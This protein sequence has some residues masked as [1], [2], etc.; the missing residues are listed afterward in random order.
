MRK[1]VFL[2]WIIVCSV[3]AFGQQTSEGSLYATG[4]Q[5]TALGACPLKST[6]MKADISGFISR[7]TVRQEFENSF[8]EPIEAVYVFPLS[9]NGA[10]DTMT[11]TIGT[12]IIRGRIMR[13]EEAKSSY[14]TAKAAGRTAALLDQERTNIFTQSVANIM[15]G[16][17]VIVEISYVETLKYEDGAYEFVFPMTVAPRYIPNG[18]KDAEKITP[19]ITTRNGSD[20]TLEVNLNAGVPVEEI[21][22][23][24][25]AID[26]INFSPNSAKITLKDEKTIP[27][28]DFILRYDV[29]GKRIE[30]AVLTHR[31]ARGGFFT[32]ILQPPDKIATEDRTPK[33]IVFVLDTSGSM[34]GFP[35]EKAKEAMKLSLEG[36]YPEDTFNIITFAGDTSI[37]F[38]RPVPATRANLDA[39]QEFLSTRRGYGGTE[40]M[41]AIKAALDPSDSQEHLRIV[42]FMTDAEVGNDDQIIAEIQRHPNARVFS[43]GI[44]SSVNR[45]LLD[46]MAAEGKGEVEYVGLQ[47]DGSAAAKRF[48]ERVRTPLLTD[49]SIDW[50]GMPVADV[51]PAKLTDL[52]SAKPV[53]LHGRYTKAAAGAIK[54]KGRLAGQPY[55]RSINV[56][57]AETEN[58]NDALSTLWARTRIDELSMTRLKAADE[59]SGKDIDDVITNIG[60]DFGLMTKFTSFLAVEDKV[61]NPNGNPTQI[62]VPS[63]LPEGMQN[64]NTT[65]PNNDEIARL[66]KTGYYNPGSMTGMMATVEVSSTAKTR[67]KKSPNDKT[68]VGSGTGSGRGSGSGSGIG[69]GSGSGT[70]STGS[71]AVTIDSSDTKITTSITRQTV[72]QL[73]NGSNF[74]SLLQIAPGIRNEALKGGFQIDG[75][76]GSENVF[77]IDGQE[78]RNYRTGILGSGANSFVIGLERYNAEYGAISDE[79]VVKVDSLDTA[80]AVADTLGGTTKPKHSKPFLSLHSTM[81]SRVVAAAE[82]SYPKEAAKAKVLG[83][84]VVEIEID[85][86]GSVVRAK[87]VSGD[88]LLTAAAEKAATLTKFAVTTVNGRR[89]RVAGKIVY[90]FKSEKQVEVF[91]RDMNAVP[92]TEAERRSYAAADKLHF[93]LYAIVDRIAKGDTR[94]T[95]NESLFVRD[96]KAQIRI[97]L[98]SLSANIKE[99]LKSAGV[100]IDS[101]KGRMVTGRIATDK[102]AA[103]AQMPEIKLISPKI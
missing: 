91:I 40:M 51:Y 60:L 16:E 6:A 75:T 30:D 102:L 82:P 36:L 62:P 83:Q 58:A 55:E 53:I 59:R 39:A 32:L 8:T 88:P 96:G 93:W 7:V 44:G 72:E 29:T 28:K 100:E 79:E 1:V 92:P 31:D 81:Q 41:T 78:V 21:R 52:F 54:L 65:V 99:R 27:N 2:L 57:F 80:K 11:M 101:E 67:F 25:H 13:R 19:P 63:M 46:K 15:P 74:S 64:G 26:Q 23:T 42:C 89:V 43:F 90:D 61:S 70:A 73:P 18:V 71:S 37:L 9:Q 47:D 12:R 20:V 56:N 14:E 4:K 24:S 49:L 66:N 45:A 50:N 48:Y 84:V 10:V 38:E 97:E 69:H 3:A 17:N 34:S 86:E 98:T 85:A 68:G 95:A 87:A 94:S 5:G 103:L 33:E 35:I 76:S 22:S 77:I